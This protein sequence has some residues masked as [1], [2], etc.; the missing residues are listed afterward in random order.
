MVTCLKF[1]YKIWRIPDM[2]RDYIRNHNWLFKAGCRCPD[3][4]SD[5]LFLVVR[6]AQ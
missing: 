2:R 1:F 5:V 6:F 3:K 4:T